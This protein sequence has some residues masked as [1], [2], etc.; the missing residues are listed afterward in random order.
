MRKGVWTW[1]VCARVVFNNLN[2]VSS[3]LLFMLTSCGV[4]LRCVFLGFRILAGLFHVK[5]NCTAICSILETR[6]QSQEKI[7]FCAPKLLI[8]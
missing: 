1:G 5:I 2:P 6:G 3:S 7:R 8:L 4:L